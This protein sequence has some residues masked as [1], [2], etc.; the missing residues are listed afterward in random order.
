MKELRNNYEYIVKHSFDIISKV[1]V[2][3]VTE[4]TYLLEFVDTESKDRITKKRFNRDYTILEEL[5]K[6]K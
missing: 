5:W 2:K 3:E 6:Y 1:K 4:K